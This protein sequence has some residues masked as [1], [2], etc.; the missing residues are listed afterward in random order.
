MKKEVVG[1]YFSEDG[2]HKVEVVR[3]SDQML[4]VVPA[5]WRSELVE[6]EGEVKESYWSPVQTSPGKLCDT[7][8]RAE[9]MAVEELRQLCGSDRWTSSWQ[10]PTS[11]AGPA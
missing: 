5:S 2:W 9:E 8:E 4:E 1:A 11:K 10:D 6:G 3:R 7:L